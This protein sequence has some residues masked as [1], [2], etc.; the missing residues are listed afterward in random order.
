[1]ASLL[2]LLAALAVFG[3]PLFAVIAGAALLGFYGAGIDLSVVAIEFYRIADMPV[4]LAIPLFTF[5]G[6][7]MGESRA[8]ERLVRLTTA[9]LGWLPGGLAIMCL[10]ACAFFTAFTGASGVTIVALGALLYPALQKAGYPES[11][12]LGLVTT[13]GSL[14]LLFAPSLP[15]ILYGIVVQQFDYTRH[16]TIESL[17][18]AGVLPGILM[19]VLLSLFSLWQGKDLR[20]S[21]RD[22]SKNDIAAALKE[23]RWELPLPLFVLGGIYSGY[24]AVSEAAAMTTLYVLVVEVLVH[25]E[26]PMGELP[27]IMRE[28]MVLV[29][30]I[31]LVLGMSLAS[32]NYLIDVQVPK[33]LF[34][35][36]GS[37]ISD[38]MT[39]LVVLNVFL[40]M[41]GAVLDIFSAL[42]I[43]VP[44]ILPVALNYGVDPVHLGIIFLANMQIGYFTPPVGMNLFIASHRFEKPIIDLYRATLP[45]FAL[46]LFAVLIITYV[47]E[48]SLMLP[49]LREALQSVP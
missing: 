9:L 15:L 41:L 11:F 26:I 32:T 30:A 4:L 25:R 19:L 3:A 17:F 37:Y 27:R 1:L 6:Y 33:K 22:L 36:I 39:F 16:V 31:L 2:L 10:A 8:P 28:S 45:F 35:W 24:F 21:W 43:V 7:L 47:P 29:G 20:V 44:L 48:L 13:S 40:L 23:S 5:A 18:I 49:N 14:G 12:N 34:D 42:V 46:L 38:R